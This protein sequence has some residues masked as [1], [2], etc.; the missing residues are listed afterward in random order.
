MPDDKMIMMKKAIS[1]FCCDKAIVVVSF[2]ILLCKH[3][4]QDE[5]KT[6]HSPYFALYLFKFWAHKRLKNHI[7]RPFFKRYSL[8]ENGA[9]VRHIPTFSLDKLCLI[10]F[11]GC[12]CSVFMFK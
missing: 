6:I 11:L 9:L 4:N 2:S 12:V 5:I 7:V 1:T 8:N 3:S 10:H